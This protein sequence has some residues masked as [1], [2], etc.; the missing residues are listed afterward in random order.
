MTARARRIYARYAPVSANPELL[1][2]I[3]ASVDLAFAFYDSDS[4]GRLRGQRLT[5]YVASC[6]AQDLQAKYH[7]ALIDTIDV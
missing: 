7:L 4:T 3:S 1:A 5:D 2:C 6:V